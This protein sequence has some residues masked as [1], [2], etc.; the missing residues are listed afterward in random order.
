MSKLKQLT[1]FLKAN[2]PERLFDSEFRS[3]M[4]EIQFIPAQR[5]LG[6]GQYRMSVKLYDVVIAWGRFPYREIDPTY[7]ALLIDVWLTEHNNDIDDIQLDLERPS[8]AAIVESHHAVLVMTLQLAENVNMREDE[9]GIV[10]FDGKRWTLTDPE[11]WLADEAII[12]SIDETGALV[13][14]NTAP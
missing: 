13:N 4:E 6:L 1:Q 11:I 10:P 12:H 14:G 5:D 7:V 9:N 2:L 8:M 3:D